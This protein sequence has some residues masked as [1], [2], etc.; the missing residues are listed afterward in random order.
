MLIPF[1][2]FVCVAYWSVVTQTNLCQH[3]EPNEE[4]KHSN[5]QDE[6]FPAVF[7]AED[8][9]IHVHH[10]CHEALHTNKLTRRR[11]KIKICLCFFFHIYTLPVKK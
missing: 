3:Y 5:C 1:T 11:V 4:G 2:V 7:T 8:R 9:R 10:G 6:E